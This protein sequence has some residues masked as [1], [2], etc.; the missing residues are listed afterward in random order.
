MAKHAWR[1]K[2]FTDGG[3]YKGYKTCLTIWGCKTCN[4]QIE[5]PLGTIPTDYD[6]TVCKGD[7]DGTD[8]NKVSSMRRNGGLQSRDQYNK[9]GIRVQNM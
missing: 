9:H 5:L 2:S 6:H 3:V 1:E 4:L 7:N 8:T